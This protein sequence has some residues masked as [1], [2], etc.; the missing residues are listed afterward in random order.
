MTKTEKKDLDVL[1]AAQVVDR[2][3]LAL[4]RERKRLPETI[5]T[6]ERKVEEFE[7]G[8]AS[9]KKRLENLVRQRKQ[10]E[11]E[12]EACLDSIRKFRAQQFLVKKNDE[13]NALGKEIADA[14]HKK[15]LLEEKILTGIDEIERAES[16]LV[17][18]AEEGRARRRELDAVRARVA[19]EVD[20]LGRRLGEAEERRAELIRS[21]PPGLVAVYDRI[22]TGKPD[23]LAVAVVERDA[24]GGCQARLPPQRINE[25]LKSERAILCEACGRILVLQARGMDAAGLG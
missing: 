9:E 25:L 6:A 23:G 18:L 12:V 13:Y 16:A 17:G 19:D 24:C 10:L 7:A 3:I 11:L 14:D 22:R 2:E 8:V 1:L 15:D 5:R 20:T 21:V 4:S